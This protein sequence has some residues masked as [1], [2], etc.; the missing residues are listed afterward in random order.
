MPRNGSHYVASYLRRHYHANGLLYPLS[1][2]NGELF[3]GEFFKLNKSIELFEDLRNFFNLDVFNIFHSTNLMANVFI[4]SRPNIKRLF[5]WFK[6]FYDGY[7]I[8]I[9]RRRNIWKTYMSW[10]FHNT[11][12]ERLIAF[13]EKDVDNHIWH[14]IEN[15]TAKEDELKSLIETIKPNFTHDETI[16]QNFIRDVKFYNEEVISYYLTK[17]NRTLVRDWWLEDLTDEF[18]DTHFKYVDEANEV[19]TRNDGFKPYSIR[20][21]T[22]FGKELPIIKAKFKEVYET[23]FKPYGYVVD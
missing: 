9:L 12:R 7:P 5:D 15:N 4:R 1:G 14:S 19:L 6:E 13:G 16:W 11:V 10:L 22:Y 8:I 23:T 3:D 18:L 21:E 17:Y 2:N 20:Y